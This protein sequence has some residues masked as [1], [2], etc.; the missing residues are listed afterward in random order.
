MAKRLSYKKKNNNKG[1]PLVKIKENTIQ[2]QREG[3]GKHV[4]PQELLE[5]T[6]EMISSN[7]LIL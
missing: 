7:S 2:K 6:L 4:F 5:E 3:K 1:R